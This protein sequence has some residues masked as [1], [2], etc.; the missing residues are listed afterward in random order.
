MTPKGHSPV[1]PVTAEPASPVGASRRSLFGA[2]GAAGLAGVAAALLLDRTAQAVPT[3]ADIAILEQAMLLEL[4][5]RDLYEVAVDSVGGDLAPVIEVMRDNHQSYAQAIAGAAGLSATGRVDEVYDSLEDAFAS[6]D[7]FAEA[8]HSL[9]QTAV[10]T[11]TALLEDYE[12]DAALSL[13]ASILV[14]E[15]RMAT[16]LAVELGVDDLDVLFGNDAAP[17]ELEGGVQ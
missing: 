4:T 17:L 13:T 15:A 5:A 7:T 14:M 16:V 1:D 11:H 10:A 8:A 12:S 6:A 3:D 9:E 2:V